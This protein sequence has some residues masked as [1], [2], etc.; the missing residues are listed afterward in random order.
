MKNFASILVLGCSVA[1]MVLG[2]V[3]ITK[4]QWLPAVLLFVIGAAVIVMSIWL[5][6]FLQGQEIPIAVNPSGVV[7]VSQSGAIVMKTSGR[8]ISDTLFWVV[9]CLYGSVMLVY[10]PDILWR[11]WLSYPAAIV[12]I[13]VVPVLLFVVMGQNLER[14]V[15]DAHGI[16]VRTVSRSITTVNEKIVW[17]DITAVKMIEYWGK[18]ANASTYDHIHNKLVKKE[19]VLLGRDGK[20][21]MKLPDLLDPPQAYQRFLETIPVW[22]K[23]AIQEVRVET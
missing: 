21:L 6:K 5:Y 18:D 10:F 1:A 22:T 8:D 16:E 14:V 17:S 7:M 9:G 2:Y 23:L 19:L 13:L 11:W 20:E 15:A 4:H 3:K 12:L